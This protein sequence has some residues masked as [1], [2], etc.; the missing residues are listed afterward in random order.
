MLRVPLQT[1]LRSD[2]RGLPMG[3][4]AVEGTRSE[5]RNSSLPLG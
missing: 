1:I 5:P 2:E 4:E 3:K